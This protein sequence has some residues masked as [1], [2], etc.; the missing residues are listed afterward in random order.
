MSY[1]YKPIKQKSNANNSL[2]H[3]VP[4]TGSKKTILSA[5]II[6]FGVIMVSMA[7]LTMARNTPNSDSDIPFATIGN[8]VIL[9]LLLTITIGIHQGIAHAKWTGLNEAHRTKYRETQ[10]V[11]FLN[12]DYGIIL[13]EYDKNDLMDGRTITVSI[14]EETKHLR[15]I[16]NQ[17]GA[18]ILGER[19]V[20]DQNGSSSDGGDSGGFIFFPISASGESFS[21]SGSGDSSGG[22]GGGG[23]G[24]GGDGGGGGGGG[25]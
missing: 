14:N 5:I 18:I 4:L 22:D 8:F 9:A 10:L 7:G 1:Y 12:K 23:D 19:I 17:E 15:L 25:D 16:A 2:P 11:P 20:R 24:G 6:I 21:D 3:F 13:N